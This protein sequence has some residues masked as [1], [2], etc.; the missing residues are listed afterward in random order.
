MGTAA[1]E[2]ALSRYG[3]KRFLTDWDARLLALTGS[4]N[5]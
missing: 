3:L 5:R 1:R 4:T 2:A